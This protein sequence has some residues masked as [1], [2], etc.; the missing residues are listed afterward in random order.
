MGAF[1]CAQVCGAG[2]TVALQM[3]Q[4]LLADSSAATRHAAVLAVFSLGNAEAQASG[5]TQLVRDARALLQERL[6]CDQG[7]GDPNTA[8]RLAADRLGRLM[9]THHK[10]FFK[11]MPAQEVSLPATPV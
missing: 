6:D 9:D 11:V 4:P 3:V 10:A 2:D 7:R 1:V 5:S 8:V